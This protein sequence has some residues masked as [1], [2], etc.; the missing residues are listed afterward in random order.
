MNGAPQKIRPWYRVHGFTWVALL[1]GILLLAGLNCFPRSAGLWGFQDGDADAVG[2]SMGL[3]MPF[4]Q[5]D[6]DVNTG[7]FPAVKEKFH[8]AALCVDLLCAFAVL[9]ALGSALE[10]MQRQGRMDGRFRIHVPTALALTA[11]TALAAAWIAGPFLEG[12]EPLAQFAVAA[13]QPNPAKGALEIYFHDSYISMD[14]G[15]VVVFKFA[16]A[17]LLLSCV[18]VTCEWLCRRRL[19]KS[20]AK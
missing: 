11:L 6:F 12:D 17:L 15:F 20:P 14:W 2:Y 1:S 10:W 3:P 4:K 5:S 16:C 13:R 9:A 19:L 7:I 18:Y 8:A